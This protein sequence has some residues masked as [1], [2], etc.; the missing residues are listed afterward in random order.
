MFYAFFAQKFLY[1]GMEYRAVLDE[2]TSFINLYQQQKIVAKLPCKLTGD[3]WKR[4]FIGAESLAMSLWN[5]NGNW[6]M[7]LY[8]TCSETGYIKLSGSIPILVEAIRSQ[9]GKPIL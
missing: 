9:K 2:S 4:L 8:P 3:N 1:P 6:K 5:A 7:E